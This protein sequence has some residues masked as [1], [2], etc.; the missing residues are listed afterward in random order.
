MKSLSLAPLAAGAVLLCGVLHSFDAA[1]GSPGQ[2]PP[3]S[4]R[5]LDL[6]TVPM[7]I[8]EPGT[9]LVRRNWDLRYV[10]ARSVGT[11]IT[12]TAS[13]VVIDFQG[14]QILFADYGVG[15]KIKGSNVTLRDGSMAGGIFASTFRSSGGET[16]LDNMSI[17]SYEG[18]QLTGGFSEMRDSDFQTH[19]ALILG[20]NAVVERNVLLG[21]TSPV[22]LA[23]DD[24]LVGNH[25]TS[26]GDDVVIVRGDRNTLIDNW[27]D[28]HGGG[29]GYG[30]VIGVTGNGNA[31]M[32]NTVMLPDVALVIDINGTS[33]TIDANVAPPVQGF[34]QPGAGVRFRQGGNFYG[35]NRMWAQTPY[36]LG[37]LPQTDWGGNIGY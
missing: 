23:N 18:V 5:T 8:T 1:A 9:Y 3:G 13:N 12:V 33:N 2:I 24:R 28:F 35:N 25:I 4:A 11:S 6:S 37:G 31:V 19:G 22:Q 15:V 7:T 29:P 26:S 10:D 17:Y 34:T 16:V 30:P 20:N 32:R 36:D 14:Y 21:E 27:I